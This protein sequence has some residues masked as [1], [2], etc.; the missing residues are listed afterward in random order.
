MASGE[1]RRLQARGGRA[2]HARA[3]AKGER[4]MGWGRYLLL[5]DLGQQLDLV[6][7]EDALNR[8]RRSV[9]AG[10]GKDY[11]QDV[12]IQAL[13]QENAEL[14]YCVGWLVN[15]LAAR[16]VLTAAEVT[17]LVERL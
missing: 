15:L 17:Q 11:D 8:L 16:R 6:D 1:R 4:I 13:W 9:S 14:K 12:Q 7:Q 3:R 10:A 2:A 5:G